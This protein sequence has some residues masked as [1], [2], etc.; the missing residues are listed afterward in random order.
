MALKFNYPM[1]KRNKLLERKFYLGENV[2][3]RQAALQ[4]MEDLVEKKIFTETQMKCKCF[5]FQFSVLIELTCNL[6][7]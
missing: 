3:E 4:E 2:D 1:K 6:C 5:F 7:L